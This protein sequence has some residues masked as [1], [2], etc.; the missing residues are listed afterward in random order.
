MTAG[1]VLVAGGTGFIGSHLLPALRARGRDV[2]VW[3]R[4]PRKARGVVTG[5]QA[6]TRVIGA[7]DEIPADA[8]I[9]HIVNLAGAPVVGPPWT[10]ARR[11][12]LIASRVQPTA[13]LLAWSAARAHRP[14]AMLSASAIG[15]YGGRDEEWLDEQSSPGADQFQS[16]LCEQRETAANEAGQLGIRAV[17][18][19]F[20]LVLGTD[21]GIFSRLALAANL[22][23]AAVLGDGR[24]WMSWIH[25]DDAVRAIELAL[26]DASLSGPVNVVA[27]GPVRQRDFQ[28]AL[29]SAMH[30]PLWLRVPAGLLRLA[31]GEMSDLLL[32]S[33]RV[34]PR[35]L[36]SRG[37]EFVY[38]DIEA[39]LRALVRRERS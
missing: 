34:A 16:Q 29:T 2:W 3:S 37:F 1:G 35:V 24:Q 27:P 38:P 11:Q 12:L 9:S 25:I 15:F 18:L 4:N 8:N 36:R 22:G 30:R 28:R 19:R 23:G 31:L 13:A 14:E 26:N 5:A 7:L 39:A 33:Q 10:R 17:H 21:G 6:R 32:R 20:G